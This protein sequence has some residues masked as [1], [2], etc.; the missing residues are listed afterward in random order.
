MKSFRI[1]GLS[2]LCFVPCRAQVSSFNSSTGNTALE[3]KGSA[4]LSSLPLFASHNFAAAA[5]ALEAAN[6]QP[7]GTPEWNFESGCS[8]LKAAFAFKS[9]GDTTTVSGIVPLALAR[10]SQAE[11]LYGSSTPAA[12]VANA[13]EVEGYIY[14][15]LLGNLTMARACYTQAV[16]LSPNTGQAALYLGRL[17]AALGELS[18]HTGR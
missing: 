5:A 2:L 10:F 18:R 1:L 9:T 11:L 3:R 14:E 15:H 13:K 12:E 16:A 17:N 6:L 4:Y 7:V 8:L